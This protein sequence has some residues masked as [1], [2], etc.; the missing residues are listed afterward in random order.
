MIE[1]SAAAARRSGA[2]VALVTGAST[3]IGRAT[4]VALAQ[5]GYR[6]VGTCRDP[7][8]LAAA[9]R[10][11]GVEYVALDLAD[12]DSVAAC[13]Q[14]IAGTGG[15]DVLVNNAG[16]SAM[17]PLEEVPIAAVEQLFAVNV[18]G[19]VQLTHLLLPTM[20]ARGGGYVIMIGSLI[21][22][23]PLPFRSTYA[24]SKLALK[25]FVLAARKEVAPFGIRMSLV[26]PAYFKTALT[27]Q[28]AVHTRPDSPYA[29]PFAA[30]R[31]AIARADAKGGDP[32]GVAKKIVTIVADENPAPV[33]V[34]GGTSPLLVAARRLMSGRMA[35]NLVA[36]QYGLRP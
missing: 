22:E 2:P 36:R 27:G 18:F 4:A 5:R 26:E 1:S 6:V 33:Y 29:G 15:V 28:R 9:D 16:Q 35:E 23:F 14:G 17:G 30:V 24:A 32:S 25:G 20:R 8:T 11:A 13:A 21:A 34:V 10:A 7:A 19:Q 31:D 3:G 12:R